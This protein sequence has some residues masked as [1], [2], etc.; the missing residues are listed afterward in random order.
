MASRD[1]LL[2]T[3][4]A[5]GIAIGAGGALT[6]A[7]DGGLDPVVLDERQ[8]PAA[9]PKVLAANCEPLSHAEGLRC[10]VGFEVPA[11]PQAG[12][13]DFVAAYLRTSRAQSLQVA[14]DT[15]QEVYART[16]KAAEDEAVELD[17]RAIDVKLA[18]R[19][20]AA[21][22]AEAERKRLA[23]EAVAEAALDVKP[24]EEVVP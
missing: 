17:V 5:A 23:E 21:E 11:V 10:S 20:A 19:K 4:A 15:A 22:A 9:E 14:V 7:Q 8:L 2:A 24:I 16:L 18:E 13:L 1:T 6:V 3:A 12:E